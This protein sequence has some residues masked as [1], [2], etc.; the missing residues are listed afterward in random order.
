MTYG[1]GSV[2]SISEWSLEGAKLT[3]YGAIIHTLWTIKLKNS[4]SSVN[5]IFDLGEEK[6]SM[7]NNV[8]LTI[9]ERDQKIDLFSE[10]INFDLKNKKINSK[11]EIYFKSASFK[12]NSKGFN[13]FQNSEGRDNLLFSKA[14]F[15]QTNKPHNGFFGKAD[16]I[17]YKSPSETFTMKGS[18]E[19]K[20]NSTSI[21]AQEIEF[22]FRTNKI[23][24]SKN[25]KIIKS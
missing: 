10:K 25:S 5:A 4:A 2:H 12:L 22:N 6:L 8:H 24:S 21:T 11:H 7:I 16:L 13:L 18:A 3:R 23:V 19:I 15:E 17:I 20:L 1:L 14:S 9:S